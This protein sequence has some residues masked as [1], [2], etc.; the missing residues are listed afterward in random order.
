MSEEFAEEK[1]E[2]SSSRR[3]KRASSSVDNNVNV[4]P[5]AFEDS[6]W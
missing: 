2:T 1:D 4:T 5:S 3:A 6:D